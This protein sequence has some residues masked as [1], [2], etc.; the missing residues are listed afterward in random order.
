MQEQQ[1]RYFFNREAEEK[2]ESNVTSL[3]EVKD[4]KVVTCKAVINI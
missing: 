4:C 3:M 2:I 1:N